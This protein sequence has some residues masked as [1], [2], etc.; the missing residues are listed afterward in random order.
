MEPTDRQI[1]YAEVLLQALRTRGRGDE[2]WEKR[3]EDC[4][5]IG[6]MSELIDEMKEELGWS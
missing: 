2:D 6:E 4:Q 1:E 5:D 3:V